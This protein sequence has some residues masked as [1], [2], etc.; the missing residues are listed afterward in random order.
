MAT[1]VSRAK[2]N[3]RLKSSLVSSGLSAPRKS[4][5][6]RLK[7]QKRLDADR[8]LVER[9][10]SGQT[11]AWSDLYRE[12][13]D[14]LLQAIRRI[15]KQS[16]PDQSLIDEI[17]A[18]VWYATVK[19]DGALLR[20]YDPTR[21]CRLITFL[22]VVAR[23]QARLHLRSERRLHERETEASQFTPREQAAACIDMIDFQSCF[24]NALTP[25]EREFLDRELLGCA[26]EDGESEEGES[27]S[28]ASRFSA[29]NSWQ[30][31]HRVEKK[32]A[33]FFRD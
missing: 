1:R 21:N 17:A 32:L 9:C 11:E 8:R 31:R 16:Q 25:R 20:R 13:H 23:F 18:R 7:A 29:T 4:E 27:E 2:M 30:L 19:N 5:A 10:L 28:G 26:S 12:C 15:L 6:A 14:R 3:T 33:A 22:T 24:L